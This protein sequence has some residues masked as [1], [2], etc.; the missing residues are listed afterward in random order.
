MAK[1]KI[2]EV[3]ERVTQTG[4]QVAGKA[5]ETV[6]KLRGEGAEETEEPTANEAQVPLER[7]TKAELMDRAKELNISGRTQMNKDE[8]VVAIRK[9]Q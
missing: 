3:R 8:L 5:F 9:R 7:R 6:N 1:N 2:D 4:A